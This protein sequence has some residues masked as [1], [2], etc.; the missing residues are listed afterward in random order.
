[1]AS[2]DVSFKKIYRKKFFLKPREIK[3]WGIRALGPTMGSGE[4]GYSYV[5]VMSEAGQMQ[6]RQEVGLFNK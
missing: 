2:V 3:I 1:M 5:R 4:K 6:T